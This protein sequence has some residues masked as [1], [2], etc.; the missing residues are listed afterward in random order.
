MPFEL[1]S[2][3]LS[4]D[5]R[6][7]ELPIPIDATKPELGTVHLTIRELPFAIN[8]A[9]RFRFMSAQVHLEKIREQLFGADGNR[10]P[11]PEEYSRLGEALG[12]Y[13]AAELEV[14]KWGVV[15]H[16]SQDFLAAGQPIPFES[17][18]E[19][20]CGESFE[21]CSARMLKLYTSITPFVLSTTRTAFSSL[22]SRAILDF[23]T[24]T[25]RTPAQIWE[26][27]DKKKDL[28]DQPQQASLPLSSPSPNESPS[29]SDSPT[30]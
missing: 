26:E 8:Q 2:D 16:R 27:F 7:L 21:V 11:T 10:E 9:R 29:T 1:P 23:Q 3:L 5:A 13:R 12:H 18:R 30:A 22:L 20:L 25:P 15:G 28:S 4:L 14:I 24:G 19:Q 6:T 17:S